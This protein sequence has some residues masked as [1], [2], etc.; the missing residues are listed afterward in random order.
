MG[1]TCAS[2]RVIS[3]NTSNGFIKSPFIPPSGAQD[4]VSRKFADWRWIRT[5]WPVIVFTTG[6]PPG[7]SVPT[8]GYI[9]AAKTALT[10]PGSRA[11]KLQECLPNGMKPFCASSPCS[12]CRIPAS[13]IIV[14][15]EIWGRDSEPSQH[16][17]LTD[18]PTQP[19]QQQRAP[20]WILNQR[21]SYIPLV[22]LQHVSEGNLMPTS[23]S[24]KT[25][26]WWIH[27]NQI[28]SLE[29]FRQL[30]NMSQK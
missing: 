2:P 11:F 20:L 19:F 30:G 27:F 7:N 29:L 9:P 10:M 14:P 4:W 26:A 22:S 16:G 1:L 15:S 24:D 5:F 21:V 17:I 25:Q 18:S 12:C 13:I 3:S 6:F 8:M 23:S 28:S